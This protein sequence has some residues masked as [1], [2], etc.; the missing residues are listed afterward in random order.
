[1]NLSKVFDTMN[2]DL[3]IATLGAYDFQKDARSFP[4]KLFNEKDSTLCK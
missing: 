3:L 4:K 2:N 1:M